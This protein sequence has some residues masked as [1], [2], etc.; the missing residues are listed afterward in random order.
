MLAKYDRSNMPELQILL[1]WIAWLGLNK[2]TAGKETELAG[3]CVEG[4]GRGEMGGS[5]VWEKCYNS[6]LLSGVRSLNYSEMWTAC[7]CWGLSL[8]CGATPHT[9]HCFMCPELLVKLPYIYPSVSL[10][11][12][13]SRSFMVF[14]T[15]MHANTYRG[16]LKQKIGWPIQISHRPHSLFANVPL[17]CV[18]T[19]TSGMHKSWPEDVFMV[20]RVSP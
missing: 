11:V 19:V 18:L 8:S 16:L 4:G 3:R 14:H 9:L 2:I 5:V 13:P 6:E 12:C 1:C 15:Y 20:H 7:Q 17:N 10:S